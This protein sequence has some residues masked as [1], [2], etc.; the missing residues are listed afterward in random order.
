LQEEGV[1]PSHYRF[2]VS[3]PTPLAVIAAFLQPSVVLAVQPAYEQRRLSEL[4]AILTTIPPQALAI[5][6]DVAVEVEIIEGV[7]P[8]PFADPRAAIPERLLRLG[9]HVPAAV[10]QPVE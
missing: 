1:L 6:W 4:D 7:F 3:L 8:H 5:Q 9:N 2:Q 10:A